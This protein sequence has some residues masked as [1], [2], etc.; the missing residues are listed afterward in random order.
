MP[1]QKSQIALQRLPSHP[2]SERTGAL[3][4]GEGL[5]RS[6]RTNRHSGRVRKPI[7]QRTVPSASAAASP[8]RT[9][10]RATARLRVDHS[11]KPGHDWHPRASE[12]NHVPRTSRLADQ[13][14]GGS[15]SS[16]RRRA[17]STERA[18][19]SRRT[20]L[21]AASRRSAFATSNPGSG[22]RRSPDG[23]WRSRRAASCSAQERRRHGGSQG[24][25]VLPRRRRALRHRVARAAGRPSKRRS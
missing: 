19:W 18:G 22:V 24:R 13:R 3:L 2:P 21:R 4:W 8:R 17:R 15:R 23:G 25:R 20:T 12:R 10:G 14:A 16:G 6:T 7:D 9:T 5:F 1:K 11:G